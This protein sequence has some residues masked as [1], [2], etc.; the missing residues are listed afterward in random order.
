MNEVM[1]GALSEFAEGGYRVLRVDTFEV[2]IFR[3][4]D[5]LVAY[6]KL[7][8][9]RRRAGLSG[10]GDPAGREDLAPDQTSRGLKFSAKKNI[11]CPWHGW[12]STS[13]P[14]AI[15]AIRSIACVRSTSGARQQCLCR[16]AC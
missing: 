16:G 15:A 9:A 1:V 7:L 6:E 4:G 10:Q 2:G 5:R 14:A 8:P 3:Q 12:S 13:S 11:V